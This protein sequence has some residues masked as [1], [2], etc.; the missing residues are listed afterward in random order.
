MSDDVVDGALQRPRL[1]PAGLPDARES[2]DAGRFY[3]AHALFLAHLAVERGRAPL[4]RDDEGEPLVGF[5]HVPPDERTLDDKRPPS[6]DRHRDTKRVVAAALAGWAPA[7]ARALPGDPLRVVVTGFGG[8]R[9][10]VD[11]PTGDF[12]RSFADVRETL[13]L[14]FGDDLSSCTLEEEG[15]ARATILVEGQ[16]RTLALRLSNLPVDDRFLAYEGESSLLGLLENDVRA[17][18]W[19]GLGVCRS[20]F[21]RVE[22]LP[23]DGG[24]R[25]DVDGLR[26]EREREP[27]RFPRGSRSLVRA[28]ERGG[29]LVAARVTS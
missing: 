26:H 28:L 16:P 22:T 7:L 10:V 27:G 23:H 6:A 1:L 3:C 18:A 17:H 25:N 14:A 5:L 24:L 8:F 4:A 2:D 11:N 12:V 15:R 20:R 13:V 19:L 29:P 21:Y 9:D